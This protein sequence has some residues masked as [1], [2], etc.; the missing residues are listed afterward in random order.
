M[1]SRLFTACV[2][3][4][5]GNSIPAILNARVESVYQNSDLCRLE[6]KLIKEAVD[7]GRR[8]GVELVPMLSDSPDLVRKL[9]T[10]EH[11]FRKWGRFLGLPVAWYQSWVT[12]AIR[13][14]YGEWS[15]LIEAIH[16]GESRCPNNPHTTLIHQAARHRI[17]SPWLHLRIGQLLDLVF[18]DTAAR[19]MYAINPDLLLKYMA[20]RPRKQISIVD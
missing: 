4:F 11:R 14:R 13:S 16:G 7:F 9:I 8:I 3:S 20:A 6:L 1:D 2:V 5:I 17:E 12:K 19:A 10:H 18:T 15:P